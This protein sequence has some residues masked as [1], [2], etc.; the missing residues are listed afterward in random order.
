MRITPKVLNETIENYNNYLAEANIPFRFT[1]HPQYEWQQLVMLDIN[2]KN[3]KQI[4]QG[5]SRDCVKVIA[6]EYNRLYRLFCQGEREV[7]Y[8]IYYHC[9]SPNPNKIVSAKVILD[10]SNT[11][12]NQ[13]VHNFI[14]NI[15]S[16]IR[17]WVDR[18]EY[19]INHS[20]YVVY[21][22]WQS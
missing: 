2:G 10:N 20:V 1:N 4:E 12:S 5:T 19:N 8:K 22:V 21:N 18:V 17:Q 11:V 7:N 6:P 15:I 3:L 16:P 9:D 13:S 14:Q